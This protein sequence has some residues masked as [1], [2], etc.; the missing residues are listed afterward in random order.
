MHAEQEQEAKRVQ[1]VTMKKDDGFGDL[2]VSLFHELP[3][4]EHHQGRCEENHCIHH[5]EGKTV[6]QKKE[7]L[8]S[9]FHDDH[10]CARKDKHITNK[11]K[12]KQGEGGAMHVKRVRE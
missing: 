9:I 4:I 10:H 8:C 5:G 1:V 12:P 7:T 3:H 11:Q 6:Q 2:Q